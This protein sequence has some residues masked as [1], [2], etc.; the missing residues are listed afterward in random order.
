MN[1]Y[2]FDSQNPEAWSRALQKMR[3]ASE[4]CGTSG[5]CAQTEQV[6]K[7]DV[8][9]GTVEIENR[10]TRAG[11]KQGP[12]SYAALA[13]TTG[14]ATLPPTEVGTREIVDVLPQH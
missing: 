12:K 11:G 8:N 10:V 7:T 9:H 3:Y 4:H 14:T 5:M 2:C 1:A 13:C 6:Q